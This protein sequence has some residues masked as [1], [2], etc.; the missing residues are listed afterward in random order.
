MQYEL[1]AIKLFD[2]IVADFH[3][4]LKD[5]KGVNSLYDYIHEW[6]FA[7]WEVNIFK[8]FKLRDESSKHF[9]VIALRLFIPIIFCEKNLFFNIKKILYIILLSVNFFS[10]WK[11]PKS[12][13]KQTLHV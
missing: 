3:L 6:R 12:I 9:F 10:F 8:E 2:L 13:I 11:F 1:E 7:I 5:I 4:S